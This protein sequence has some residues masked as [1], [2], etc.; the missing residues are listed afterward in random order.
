MKR[1]RD[2]KIVLSFDAANED[3]NFHDKALWQL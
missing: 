1:H 3:F 2:I